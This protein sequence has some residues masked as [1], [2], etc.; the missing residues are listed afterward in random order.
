MGRDTKVTPVAGPFIGMP[1]YIEGI[2]GDG[3][4]IVRFDT[5]SPFGARVETGVFDARNLRPRS[6]D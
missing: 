4:V 6:R 1:G 3:L 2:R 5:T